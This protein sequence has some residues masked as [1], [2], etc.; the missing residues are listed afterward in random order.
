M[1]ATQWS[2]PLKRDG[3]GLSRP[4][5]LL[6]FIFVNDYGYCYVS[7]VF[8]RARPVGSHRAK[9][10]HCWRQTIPL[11]GSVVPAVP[12]CQRIHVTP[13]LSNMEGDV[14]IRKK[15]YVDIVLSS[16]TYTSQEV[17]ERMTKVLMASAPSA[18]KIMVVTLPDGEI[19]TV[20]ATGR[21]PTS[22][23]TEKSSPLASNASA[24]RKLCSSKV[25]SPSTTTH[26][27]FGGVSCTRVDRYRAHHT[28]FCSEGGRGSGVRVGGTRVRTLANVVKLT[29]RLAVS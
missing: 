16:G 14:N 22:S 28:D 21:R 15:L 4:A 2:L 23:Q 3:R 10:H 1:H 11:R 24:A 13:F 20:G 27:F 6:F 9:K 17:S 8:D 7:S 26:A 19:F 25:F 5:I 29:A 12:F 18:M